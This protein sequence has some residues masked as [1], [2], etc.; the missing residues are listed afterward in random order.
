LRDRK[1]LISAAISAMAGSISSGPDAPAHDHPKAQLDMA[2]VS[3]AN[4]FG[5][6]LRSS[7]EGA[8]VPLA[9]GG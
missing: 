6:L 5:S 3:F 2:T 1:F 8:G 4:G 9:R 7:A